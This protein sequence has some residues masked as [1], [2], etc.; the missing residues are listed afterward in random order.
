MGM[1]GG[2]TRRRQTTSGRNYD[3]KGI[4][5]GLPH[6]P[7]FLEQVAD[8]EHEL[9]VSPFDS[10][11]DTIDVSGIPTIH[12]SQHRDLQAG[13]SLIPGYT[14]TSGLSPASIFDNDDH[15]SVVYASSSH[16]S[17][18]STAHSRTKS[19]PIIRFKQRDSSSGLISGKSSA[20]SSEWDIARAYGGPRYDK[21]RSVGAMSGI[22]VDSR[23]W[24]ER[25]RMSAS[26]NMVG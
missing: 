20:S 9:P 21:A 8:A 6:K 7:I 3:E 15:S 22:S 14:G 17:I 25:M 18:I 5:Q 10:S 26:G 24:D 4:E 19:A 13:N 11:A 23:E 2:D 16:V 1:G 12:K